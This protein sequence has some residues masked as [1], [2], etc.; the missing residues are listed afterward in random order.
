MSEQLTPEEMDTNAK[1]AQ[2]VLISI[3][4]KTEVTVFDVAEWWSDW[5]LK[6]GHKR[7]GRVLLRFKPE[8]E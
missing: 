2:D 8:K 4:E 1:Q 6:C 7:L 5:Y 3:T